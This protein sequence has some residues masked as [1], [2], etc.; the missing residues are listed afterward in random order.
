MPTPT[1]EIL[2]LLQTFNGNDDPTLEALNNPSYSL[3][4]VA[5]YWSPHQA[6][7]L[8][9]GVSPIDS[10]TFRTLLG[11]N[12]ISLSLNLAMQQANALKKDKKN[13]ERQAF[14][15]Y[16]TMHFPIPHNKI[17]LLKNL[18]DALQKAIEKKEI[19][20]HTEK[21]EGINRILLDPEQVIDWAIQNK[22]SVTKPLIEGLQT[23]GEISLMS[24][25]KIFSDEISFAAQFERM[26]SDHNRNVAKMTQPQSTAAA[27]V[28]TSVDPTSLSEISNKELTSP[29]SIFLFHFSSQRGKYLDKN[30]RQQLIKRLQ[31]FPA[32]QCFF[33]RE[34]W[35]PEEAILAYYNI[36]WDIFDDTMQCHSVI[37]LVRTI[38]GLID[39]DEEIYH[40]YTNYLSVKNRYAPSNQFPLQE[41]I[42]FLLKNEYK[43]PDHFPDSFKNGTGAPNIAP[44][45]TENI[46][47]KRAIGLSSPTSSSTP[48]DSPAVS[49]SKEDLLDDLK[50][51]AE[52]RRVYDSLVLRKNTVIGHAKIEWYIE[53]KQIE[54][55]G[56]GKLTPASQ[57]SKR[58]SLQNVALDISSKLGLPPLKMNSEE[59]AEFNKVKDNER[60]LRAYLE[61]I[62]KDSPES[63]INPSWLS[64]EK[65]KM[66]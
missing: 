15:N 23:R 12:E 3:Y 10:A 58:K 2:K 42:N 35:S 28:A 56:T 65:P 17:H 66:K 40:N 45:A 14:Y 4:I 34:T 26:R 59:E 13:G 32:K 21:H 8:I 25:P 63:L 51:I 39:K 49:T 57:L 43:I 60:E 6:V 18:N 19:K 37:F 54:K 24:L 62:S 27:V 47:E 30:G 16:V 9:A 11:L 22:F 61:K 53:L 31:E 38:I 44:T 46:E 7:C 5:P 1:D 41:F 20:H 33:C 29:I 52:K 64:P 48:I 50:P 55:D 36:S